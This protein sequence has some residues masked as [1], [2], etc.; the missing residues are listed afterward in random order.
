[1]QLISQSLD[2]LLLMCDVFSLRLQCVSETKTH[3]AVELHADARQHV[4]RFSA[5]VIRFVIHI[6]MREINKRTRSVEFT[7]SGTAVLSIDGHNELK[8]LC[9]VLMSGIISA[10]FYT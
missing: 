2:I 6:E 1:M 8:L 9:P 5:A 3:Q 4:Q 10:M 7:M